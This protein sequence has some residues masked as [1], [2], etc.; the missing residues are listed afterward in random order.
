M[1]VDGD[2]VSSGAVQ[3]TTFQALWSG[4][5]PPN[6]VGL[7]ERLKIGER[8]QRR[9]GGEAQL[10]AVAK[11]LRAVMRSAPP[12]IGIN[13]KPADVS[14]ASVHIGVMDSWPPVNV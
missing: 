3:G 8:R 2:L 1:A 10:T 11:A 12:R 6:P 9:F 14:G 13:A 4:P 7:D 5:A